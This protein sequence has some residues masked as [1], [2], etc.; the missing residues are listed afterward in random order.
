[1]IKQSEALKLKKK[2]ENKVSKISANEPSQLICE[3]F[4]V[5]PFF[6]QICCFLKISNYFFLK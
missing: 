3:V 2:L 1:M 4:F 5:D 6:P